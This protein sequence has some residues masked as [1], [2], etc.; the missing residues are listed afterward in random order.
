MQDADNREEE[1]KDEKAV[2]NGGSIR[3]A[4]SK[5]GG[6]WQS[7]WVSL[8]GLE[9]GITSSCRQTAY[10]WWFEAHRPRL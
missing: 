5:E 7:S 10:L 3:V 2:E 4:K 1:E 8:G 6:A 9:A